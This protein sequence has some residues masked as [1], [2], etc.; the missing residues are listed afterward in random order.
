M[1]SNPLKLLSS[2]N[3][4]VDVEARDRALDILVPLLELDSPRMAARMGNKMPSNDTKRIVRTFLYDALFPILTTNIG[5]AN[6]SLMTVQ[7]FR[8]LAQAEE[9]TEGFLYIQARLVE[10]ASRDPRVSQLV[11]NDLY[12]IV[13]EDVDDDE[14]TATP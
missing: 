14:T 6:A 5:R 13:P 8:E 10:L 12:P 1:R 11:W 7:L 4:T 2:Y 3:T 9:N